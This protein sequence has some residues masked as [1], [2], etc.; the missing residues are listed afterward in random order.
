[1]FTIDLLKG[2]GIPIKSRPEGI[3]I[4]AVTFAVPIISAILIFSF[5]LHTT[6]L[7][8]IK[9]Q[10]VVKWQTEIDKLSD[11]LTLQKSFEKEKGNIGN[12][13]SEVSSS[14]GRHAQWSPVLEVVVENMPR[15]MVLTTLEVKQ[16]SVRKKVPK[17][18]DPKKM[19]DIA[20]P[21]RTLRMQISGRPQVS[22]DKV[23]RDFRERL[24]SSALLGPKL[25]NIR[26]SQ[27]VETFGNQDVETYAIDCVFKPGL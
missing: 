5:Y 23:V 9:K 8:S 18:D 15:S 7:T 27:Q 25:E 26:V 4:A 14:I 22:C 17:K 13:L 24:C 11:A 3:A 12:C 6:I 10:E 21:S 19:V 20:V 2:R 1:M 16:G